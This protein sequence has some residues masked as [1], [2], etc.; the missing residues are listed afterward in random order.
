[1]DLVAVKKSYGSKRFCSHSLCVK[2][3]ERTAGHS[4]FREDKNQ[5]ALF[6][7]RFV[8]GKEDPMGFG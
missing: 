3:L 1:M 2:A 4:L 7:T 6:R 5:T 8:V